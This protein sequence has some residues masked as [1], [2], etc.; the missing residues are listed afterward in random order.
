MAG[1][2]VAPY[3]SWKSPI[4]SDLIVS[5]TIGLSEVALHGDTAYWIESRPS[6]GGRSVIVSQRDG[7]LVQDITP[8]PFNARS[9]VHEM[10]G[11]TFLVLADCIY[12]SNFSDNRVYRHRNG[13]EI[14]PV[15]AE[16]KMRYGDFRNDP[17][18]H[19]LICVREDHTVSD[20]HCVNTIVAI[21]TEGNADRVLVEGSDFY[22]T[23]RLSPGGKTLAWLEWNHPS[24]PWDGTRLCVA[25]LQQD[26]SVGSP[27]CIAGGE[28]ESVFQPEWSPDG[29]LH[30]VSDRTG[31]WNLYRWRGGRIDPLCAMAA[32]FGAPQWVLGMSF[33]RFASRDRIVCIYNEHGISRIASLNTATKQLEVIPTPY[34]DIRSLQVSGTRAVFVAG[35]PVEPDSVVSLDCESGEARVLRR[36]SGTGVEEGYLS[37]AQPIEFPTEN[38]FFAHAFYYAP[39]SKDYA[40]PSTERSP[41]IVMSHGGPTSSTSSTLNLRT[42]FWTSRG[43]AVVDVNYGGSTGYG[44]QYRERL[45]GNWGIVDVDDCVNAARYLVDRGEVDPGRLIIRGGSAGGY[46][47]LA[48][49]TFRDV[50]KAGASYFGISDLKALEQDCHKFESHYNSSLVAPYPEAEAIYQQRSPIHHTGRLSCPIILFQGSEDKIVPPNQ[51]EKMYRAL[52]TR[53][54]PVAYILFEGEGH[55][56]RKAEYIKLSLD[57]ELYFYSKVFGFDTDVYP[58][59]VAERFENFPNP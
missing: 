9:R 35:S 25:E 51:S 44:R 14:Q 48:A 27:Q 18:R 22:S 7:G 8:Q 4:T 6:E 45:R 50:F 2:K 47:T 42:Q 59:R 57:A 1:K 56:F 49:L 36:S 31:W 10:G 12:F 38:G 3:G 55:G 43:F 52:R 33:Y 34:T 11:G 21:H 15:T 26:G 28:K 5:G 53:G 20:I 39:R 41:L 16:G 54:I 37:I 58:E 24:M 17:E 32:E 46:T 19:R 40:G 13:Q 23:P 29:V 30:F